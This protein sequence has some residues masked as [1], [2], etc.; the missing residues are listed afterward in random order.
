METSRWP[1]WLPRVAAESAIVVFSVMFA[2]AMDGWRQNR[3]LQ[4]Q[5]ANA[6]VAFAD[7]IGRNRELLT[8]KE[9]LPYHTSMHQW[10]KQVS[11]AYWKKNYALADSL[12][13]AT[14][15]F[16]TGVHPP[17][18]RDAVWRSL[19]QSDLIRHMEPEELFLLA[20]VYREQGHLDRGFENMLTVWYEPSP[21]KDVLA[22][23][24]DDMN[25]TRMFLADVIAAEGRLLK[26]YDEARAALK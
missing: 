13:R 18:L 12:Q 25:S 5:V 3:E 15:L 23:K 4:R 22:Y 10:Y 17:P 14:S 11:D 6:R 19:S 16:N 9:Y 1:A 7:E 21:Y 20:D 26:R 24:I 8:A 2:L